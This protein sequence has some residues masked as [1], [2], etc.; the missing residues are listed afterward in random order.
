MIESKDLDMC[1]E[2]PDFKLKEITEHNQ[3]VSNGCPFCQCLAHGKIAAGKWPGEKEMCN[4]T[5]EKAKIRIGPLELGQFGLVRQ[6]LSGGL[7]FDD[8]PTFYT[9]TETLCIYFV[10]EPSP[11]DLKVLQENDIPLQ[12]KWGDYALRR[13]VPIEEATL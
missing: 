4:D 12:I 10:V 5:F 11:G 9:D 1:P 6:M 13:F 8:L 3:K 2:H 7:N